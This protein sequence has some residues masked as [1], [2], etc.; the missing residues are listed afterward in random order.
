LDRL[1]QLLAV[2]RLGSVVSASGVDAFL[3]VPG[4]LA[5]GCVAEARWIGQLATS[6]Q[7][8]AGS[9]ASAKRTAQGDD[10]LTVFR[11]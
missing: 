8:I 6:A 10:N 1:D 4:W 9:E 2:D 7:T 3:S 11:L 5:R